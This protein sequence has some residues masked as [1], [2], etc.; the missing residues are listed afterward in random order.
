MSST[1]LQT[2]AARSESTPLWAVALAGVMLAASLGRQ[3]EKNTSAKEGGATPTNR[4]NN[5]GRGRSAETPSEIP[6]RGWKDILTRA[7][8]GISEDRILLIAAGATFYVILSIFPG[9]AA[10][11]SIYGLFGN[12]ATLANQL[13]TLTNVAP[14]GAIEVL[15][16]DL[17]RLASGG[18][19]TLGIGFFVS[20]AISLW[21]AN[22]G[23][24][25]LFDAL[26]IVYEEKEK[27]GFFEYYLATLTFT[28][29]A[30]IF[31]LLAIAVVVALPIV[32]NFIPLP[33]G[34]DLLLKI[35]RWPIL[36]VLVGLALA[37]LYR[38]GPSRNQ[39]RWRW[40]TWGSA[41]ATAAWVAVSVLFS[42]Y[43]ES[44]GSYNKTYGSLGAIVGFMTWIWLSLVVVLIGAKIDAE[45]EHQTAS[46]T[47]E[48]QAKPL[49]ARG[50]KMA[51][52][53][54]SAEG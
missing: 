21:S 45:T 22:S 17:T 16:D 24:S 44:F 35:T 3:R 32:L 41:F 54:G 28:V 50:A 46:D 18:G 30:I 7:Y 27:R 42:W 40:V 9:I 1:D 38:Y 37:L 31:M 13:D 48:G 5:D 26:N 49:G 36:F 8:R 39:P 4:V 6:F 20:L 34:S 11:I 12:P 14:S 47:T 53:V 2:G 25:A 19:T 33:G 29:G 51:D 23:V 43:V 10:L 15:R 52:S